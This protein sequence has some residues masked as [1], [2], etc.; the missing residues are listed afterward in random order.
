MRLQRETG[1]FCIHA[2]TFLH[3]TAQNAESH[4]FTGWKSPAQQGIRDAR[5]GFGGGDS[6]KAIR[7]F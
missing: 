7:I 6:N 5:N 4:L 3:D 2:G 1:C